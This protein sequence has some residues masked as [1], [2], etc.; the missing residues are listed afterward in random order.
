MYPAS[1]AGLTK[2]IG[3]GHGIRLGGIKIPF[4]PQHHNDN[5]NKGFK[6]LP[7]QAAAPFE[8]IESLI[9]NL[10]LQLDAKFSLALSLYAKS[11]YACQKAICGYSQSIVCIA[12]YLDRT[13]TMN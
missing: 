7:R 2:G 11:S 12:I 6:G 9:L 13:P 8:F 4:D 3:C 5:S 10:V 1:R